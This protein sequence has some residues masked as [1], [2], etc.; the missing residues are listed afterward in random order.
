VSGPQ[1][2]YAAATDVGLVREVNEDAHLVAPPVFAVADGM[3]GHAGGDVASAI[4]V[5]ELGRLAGSAYDEPSA[6]RAVLDALTASQRR[7]VEHAAGGVGRAA[8]GTT[9]AA[10][11][12]VADRWLVVNLGDSRVYRTC[13][14]ELV[15]V[16]RDHSLVQELLDAG[17]I[18]ADE[19]ADHQER[20]VITRALGGPAFSEPD[21]WWVD[22]AD[23]D[24][25]LLC[26]DGV[27]GFVDDAHIAQV[28]ATEADPAAAAAALVAAS[29]DAGGE[30]NATAVV[31][32]VVG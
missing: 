8:P 6:E 26:T 16:S 12:Q 17:E 1:L 14:G 25:L 23:T 10:A 19:V 32:D 18:T 9:V 31:V 7:I 2:R 5:E 27:N 15:Q 13:G 21:L 24:R 11:V 28:L 3:G 22:V 30:D 20:H 29:L 4:V